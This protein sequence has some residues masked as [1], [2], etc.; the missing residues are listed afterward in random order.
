[1]HR[2]RLPFTTQHGNLPFNQQHED[3]FRV[4]QLLLLRWLLA[5]GEQPSVTFMQYTAQQVVMDMQE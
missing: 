2:F 5:A 4:D 3:A 1:M